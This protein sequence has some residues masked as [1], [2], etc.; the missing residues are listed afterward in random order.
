MIYT[1]QDSCLSFSSFTP[2]VIN[3]TNLLS[4]ES[5]TADQI[6]QVQREC[7]ETGFLAITGGID[8]QQLQKLFSAAEQFFDLPLD[9]KMQYVV[10]DMQ[11]GRGYE[12]S[13]EHQ[14]RLRA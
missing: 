14:V 1:E 11:Q 4:G 7:L 13:P 5:P 12:I 9:V 2:P 6:Q 8:E 10:G 3:I